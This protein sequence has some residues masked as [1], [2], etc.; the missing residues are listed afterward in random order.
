MNE[1]GRSFLMNATGRWLVASALS[2]V[3]L[4]AGCGGGGR[5]NPDDSEVPPQPEAAVLKPGTWVVMGSSTAAGAGASEG[6]SWVDLLRIDLMNRGVQIENL[7]KGGTV[8][9]QGL[10]STATPVAGRPLPDPALNIDQ[11]LLRSPTMVLLAYPT[12]DTAL[13]YTVD[14]TVNNLLSLRRV[15]L[16]NSVPVMVLST[17]PRNLTSAQLNQLAQIDEWLAAAIGPCFVGVRTALAA[18][19]GRLAARYDAGDGVHP[20]EEGHRVI[21]ARVR[22]VIDGGKCV[23]VVPT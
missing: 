17:Q 3:I 7:A 2:F 16:T 15:A 21:A 11:A 20:N 6:N 13:G 23:R 9:Y 12:N 1:P 19:D 18:D 22:E 14:E 4:V 10:S 8:T 5:V